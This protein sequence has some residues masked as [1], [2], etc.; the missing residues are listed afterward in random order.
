MK[1]SVLFALI[2]L[3]VQAS[4][5][6]AK[7][8]QFTVGNPEGFRHL[9][10]GKVISATPVAEKG[11]ALVEARVDFAPSESTVFDVNT[12]PAL[13][14]I[15]SWM[16]R[17]RSPF[18]ATAI[19]LTELHSGPDCL[20]GAYFPRFDISK[21]AQSRRRLYFAQIVTAACEAGV[22]VRLF[23]ALISQESRYRPYARSH[24]GAMGMA[25]LMPGTARY[26]RV[27]DPWDP[28][29]NLR[30]GAQYLREQLDRYGSW[31]LALAAYNA[32]PG[33]VDKFNGIPPFRETRNYVQTILRS[34]EGE[35][36]ANQSS[37]Q[38]VSAG[39][40]PR[41]QLAYFTRMLQVPED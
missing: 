20:T 23:D 16:R 26:L 18:Q 39:T 25:Q 22:P 32:G 14:Y 6:E 11:D 28:I 40:Y 2:A 1:K 8:E 27:S 21:A 12:L 29:E 4:A 17:G 41:V 36:S 13:P 19:S 30:G 38:T 35:A 24:A 10:P 5:Q 15:P 7:L 3:S 34:L 9:I 31:D 33:N 37:V